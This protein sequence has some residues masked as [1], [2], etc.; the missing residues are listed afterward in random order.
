MDVVGGGQGHGDVSPSPDGTSWGVS[1]HGN[2]GSG[3][4]DLVVGVT[5]RPNCEWGETREEKET[6]YRTT[7]TTHPGVLRSSQGATPPVPTWKRTRPEMRV[8]GNW[9]STVVGRGVTTEARWWRRT[10]TR[11][12]SLSLPTTLD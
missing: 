10:G 5:E 7:V 11:V 8:M 4:F 6:L 3:P 2:P 9:E 1:P 12:S